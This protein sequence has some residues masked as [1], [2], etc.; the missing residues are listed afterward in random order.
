MHI[1]IRTDAKIPQTVVGISVDINM[2]KYIH[3]REHTE[4]PFHTRKHTATHADTQT[5][6]PRPKNRHNV[7]SIRVHENRSLQTLHDCADESFSPSLQ[8]PRQPCC[9]WTSRH[10]PICGDGALQKKTGKSTHISATN[11]TVSDNPLLLFELL[12]IW[13]TAI[14]LRI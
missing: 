1:Y 13:L 3:R 9:T 6:I 10:N 5:E 4:T 2:H 12:W 7:R 14:L 11:F 8:R